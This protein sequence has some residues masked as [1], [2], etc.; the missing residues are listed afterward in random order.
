MKF[1]SPFHFHSGSFVRCCSHADTDHSTAK[2]NHRSIDSL[3]NASRLLGLRTSFTFATVQVDSCKIVAIIQVKKNDLAWAS[4]F[5]NFVL[6]VR[7]QSLAD[8]N[9]HTTKTISIITGVVAI[10][11]MTFASFGTMVVYFVS[12]MCFAAI[13]TAGGCHFC[14]Y[15]YHPFADIASTIA[16]ISAA[17]GSITPSCFAGSLRTSGIR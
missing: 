15:C 5:V 6:G 13:V 16:A 9:S 8:T 12:L 11:L 10:T 17:A 2:S 4:S 3:S 1:L 14:Q 7:F